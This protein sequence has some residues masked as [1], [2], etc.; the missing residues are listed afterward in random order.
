MKYA[1][2]SLMAPLFLLATCVDTSGPRQLLD[3]NGSPDVTSPDRVVAEVVEPGDGATL[4]LD[5]RTLPD[6]FTETTSPGD[7]PELGDGLTP[8]DAPEAEDTPA[9]EAVVTDLSLP[10][11]SKEGY[12]CLDVILCGQAQECPAFA[13]QECWAPCYQGA[14]EM[15]LWELSLVTGCYQDKCEGQPLEPDESEACLWAHCFSELY[16]CIG[17][18]GDATCEEELLCQAECGND[19]GACLLDCMA[20]A[21][22]EAVTIALQFADVASDF[23][24]LAYL[25]ECVE[26]SGEMGCGEMLGC[27]SDCGILEGEEEDGEAE[28]ACA[29]ECV[30]QGTPKAKEMYLAAFS[31]GAEGPCPDEWMKCLGGTGEL[32]C[33]ETLT[34][35]MDCAG[36]DGRGEDSDDD[37]FSPCLAQASPEGLEAMLVYLDCREEM[38]GGT[39][40]YCPQGLV[41]TAE[42]GGGEG[43]LTCG[44]VF[45]CTAE[46]EDAGGD[47]T[48][49][50]KC[51]LELSAESIPDLANF[52]GCMDEKCPGGFQECPE[53]PSCWPLCS[54]TEP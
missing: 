25:F 11:L 42:C 18:E 29:I 50:G 7:A 28:M 9:P 24:F 2:L 32:S 1:L 3:Q 26:G 17:G 30:K 34:C 10:D 5:G 48:C 46:C 19:G 47:E 45:Q 36:I 51:I 33:A 31:C 8:G 15:T 22:E 4:P 13:D 41:C 27:M 21:G 6:E 40:D 14:S 20:E 38:C 52:A 23:G 39:M 44:G 43:D 53:F 37:C 16:F 49:F 12:A 54:G 35:I